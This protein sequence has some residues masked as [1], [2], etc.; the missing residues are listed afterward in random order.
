MAFAVKR[1][2]QVLFCA[3]FG[4]IFQRNARYPD[5]SISPNGTVEKSI[6][7]IDLSKIK[8]MRVFDRKA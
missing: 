3:L 1:W 7:M 2:G 6:Y 4:A 8:S 5:D